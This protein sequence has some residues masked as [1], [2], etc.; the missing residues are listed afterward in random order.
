MSPF[1][2][3]LGHCLPVGIQLF[4]LVLT[5]IGWGFWLFL[6][7]SKRSPAR[8]EEFVLCG[9]GGLCGC[10][11]LLQDLVCVGMRIAWSAWLGA[12][13]AALGLVGVLRRIAASRRTTRIGRRPHWLVPAGVVLLVF[14]FQASGV[15]YWGR[16]DYYGYAR[17]DQLTYVEIAQFLIEKPFATEYKDVGLHPW[18]VKAI[19]MKRWRIGQSVADAYVAVLTGTDSEGAYG[20]TSVIFVALVSLS[21]LALLRS[22]GAGPAMACLG[23]IWAGIIP[24]ITQD[25]LDGFF[26]QVSTLFCLPAIILAVR[27]A[28]RDF[29]FGLVSAALLLTFLFGSYCEVF[30]IGLALALGLTAVSFELCFRRRLVLALACV[31]LPLALLFPCCADY[32]RLISA[33]YHGASDP[34]ILKEWGPHVGTWRGWSEIFLVAPAH[35]IL[36][37]R[38]QTICGFAILLLVIAGLFSR[39]LVRTIQLAVMALVPASILGLLLSAEQFPKYAFGKLLICFA[40]LWVTLAV[41]GI[42]RLRQAVL[43]LLARRRIL[44]LPRAAIAL[45]AQGCLAVLVALAG[46]ASWSKLEV[47][48]ANGQGLPTMNSTYARAVYRELDTHPERAYLLT[49]PHFILNGWFCYHARHSDFYSAV[50]QIGDRPVADFQ[51]CAAPPKSLEIW[52][53][54]NGGVRRLP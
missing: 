46:W 22:L 36:L 3:L 2:T 42:C 13:I 7:T 18:M 20:T 8:L 17:Q 19:D 9:V 28:N 25:H 40:P 38:A 12:A 37:V 26:P 50:D 45:G 5:A 1:L 24:A 33:Q 29:R 49:E 30:P 48:F 16:G 11:L 31:V 27:V 35:D 6:L 43:T 14:G 4:A 21:V 10:W 54:D 41:L 15:L 53:V 39:N 23:G 47:V 44:I 51:F 32:L 34:N 52:A